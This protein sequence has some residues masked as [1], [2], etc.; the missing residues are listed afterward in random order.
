MIFDPLGYYRCLNADYNTD[1]KIL[2]INY[3]E[4]AK[5]WH[6]DHNKA[7]NALEEFQKISIAYEILK[8]LKLAHFIIYWHLLMTRQLFRT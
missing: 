8:M 7:E 5:F 4:K 2:K 3:R 1:E 6:P